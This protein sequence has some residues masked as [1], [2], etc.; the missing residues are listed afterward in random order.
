MVALPQMNNR[1]IG[2]AKLAGALDNGLEHRPDIGRRRGDD[3]QDV[4]ASGLIGQR[5]RQL[6]RLGLHLVEQPHI[7]DRDHGLVGEGLQQIDLLA[8]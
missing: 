6:A 4:G 7:L 5:L 8:R 2:V 1:I 3:L